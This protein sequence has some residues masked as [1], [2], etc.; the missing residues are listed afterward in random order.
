MSQVPQSRRINKATYPLPLRVPTVQ[1]RQCGCPIPTILASPSPSTRTHFF[2][3]GLTVQRMAL[4]PPQHEGDQ[5]RNVQ[6]GSPRARATRCRG[7]GGLPQWDIDL[8]WLEVMNLK[9]FTRRIQVTMAHGA[10]STE[11]NPDLKWCQNA[12]WLAHWPE[13][14]LAARARAW[15]THIKLSVFAGSKFGCN[16]LCEKWGGKWV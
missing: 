3:G 7:G 8:P 10:C 4:T 2:G 15:Q 5:C 12:P 13:L 1:R 14:I 11:Y 9:W 16:W 6:S